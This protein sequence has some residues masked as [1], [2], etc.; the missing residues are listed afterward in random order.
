MKYIPEILLVLVLCAGFYAVGLGHGIEIKHKR[1]AKKPTFYTH[2]PKEY[3]VGESVQFYG[4]ITE[5][6][7]VENTRLTN[8]GSVPCYAVYCDP[9]LRERKP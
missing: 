8:G 9:D 3:V 6:E 4:I 7:R 5:I 1:L 2:T